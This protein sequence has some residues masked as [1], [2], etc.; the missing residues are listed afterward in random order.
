MRRKVSAAAVTRPIAW[1]F[2]A[3]SLEPQPKRLRLTLAMKR[4]KFKN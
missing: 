3:D 1:I 4:L 2:E